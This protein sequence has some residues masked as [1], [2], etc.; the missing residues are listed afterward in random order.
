MATSFP[1][2]TNAEFMLTVRIVVAFVIRSWNNLDFITM[3][4][5]ALDGNSYYTA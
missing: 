3:I 4:Y 1:A 2:P 5:E